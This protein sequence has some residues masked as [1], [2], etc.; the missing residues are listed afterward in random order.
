MTL[1]YIDGVLHYNGSQL[2]VM[3]LTHLLIYYCVTDNI[4]PVL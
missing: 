2:E 1:V 4:L 3:Q